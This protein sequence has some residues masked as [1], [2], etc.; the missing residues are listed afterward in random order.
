M[1]PTNRIYPGPGALYLDMHE[2]E[3]RRAMRDAL[4]DVP[5]V[6]GVNNHM[7]SLITRHPGH[8]EWV[9][10]ELR[11]AGDLY[12]IDSRTSARTVAQKL[13]AEQGLKNASRTVFIDP[14]RDNEI[15]E[16][17]IKR[18]ISA[19]HQQNGVIAI[20]HPYP[21]T[22]DLL[23]EYLPKLDELGIKL[24]PPSVLVDE[25]RADSCTIPTADTVDIPAPGAVE[26][27]Q[28]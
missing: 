26:E 5:H 21:Q 10:E 19:A 28:P 23:E 20:A 18:F 12:F 2:H 22:L 17:Q 1:E 24:V 4:A 9:M 25:S 11:K 27:M 14:S 7:G 13:A 15:I 8:M 3:V 6:R 16:R